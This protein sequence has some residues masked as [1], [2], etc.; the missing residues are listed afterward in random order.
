MKGF[1]LFEEFLVSGGIYFEL[2]MKQTK[3]GISWAK[4]GASAKVL[5]QECA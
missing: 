5:R 2:E 1:A 4:E 3:Q